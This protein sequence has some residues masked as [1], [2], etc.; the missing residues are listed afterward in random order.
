MKE[1]AVFQEHVDRLEKLDDKQFD[2]IEKMT[3]KSNDLTIEQLELIY[4]MMEQMSAK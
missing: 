1:Y 3:M 4:S 2:L